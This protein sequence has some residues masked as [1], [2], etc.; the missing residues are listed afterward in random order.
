LIPN[1][2]PL[3]P[4]GHGKVS[5]QISSMSIHLKVQQYFLWDLDQPF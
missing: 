3:F 1:K 4:G 5:S 2:T